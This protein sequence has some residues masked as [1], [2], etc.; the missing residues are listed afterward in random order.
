MNDA[1]GADAP[2]M[3]AWTLALRF[4]LEM[5]ALVGMV[6]GGRALIDG[7]AGQ[8]VGI[9]VA[10]VAAAAWGTFNVPGDPSRSGRAPVAVS[11]I[12][13]LCVEFD[14][15]VFGAAG[16]MLAAPA[17]GIVFVVLVAV[18]YATTRPRLLWLL[19]R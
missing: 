13:R 18:H 6:V 8:V 17:V 10:V 1:A 4:V 5:V 9:V 12:V 11:G 16:W 2:T 19:S 14:V 15:L 3:P 7:T